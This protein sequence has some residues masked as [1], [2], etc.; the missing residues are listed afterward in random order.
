[1]R[2]HGTIPFRVPAKIPPRLTR[3]AAGVAMAMIAP[4]VVRPQPAVLQ[5]A[6]PATERTLPFPVGERLTYRIR[7]GKVGGV[8]R[9]VMQVD[10]QA[11]VRGRNAYVLRFDFQVRVGPV[12]VMDRTGSWLDP[13]RMTTLRFFKYERHPLSTHEEEV[14][15]YPDERRWQAANGA[16]GESE[17][18]APLD[19]LSFIYFLRTLAFAG[20]SAVT[21]GR[22]FD[23]ERN[24]TIVRVVRREAVVSTA[25]T[26]ATVLLEMRVKDPRRYRGEGTILVNISEDACRLPVRIRSVMPVFGTTVLLLESYSRVGARCS[27]SPAAPID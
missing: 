20:D 3:L 13:Q 1:M 9:G 7:I 23:R 10:G 4:A 26:F 27:V 16:R 12:R 15:V 8:G 11:S 6:A 21:F 25:G 5:V 17:S 14:E 18:E 19:E 22:H 24:P 2:S